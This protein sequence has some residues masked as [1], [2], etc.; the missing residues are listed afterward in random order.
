MLVT[1]WANCV[2]FSRSAQLNVVADGV[3]GSRP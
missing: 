1:C 2:A 3:T